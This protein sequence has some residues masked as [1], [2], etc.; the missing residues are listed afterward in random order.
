MPIFEYMCQVCGAGFEQLIMGREASVS[1]PTCGS[2][3]VA[4]QFSTLSAQ[5][6]GGFVGSMG[7]GCGCAPSG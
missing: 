6:T 1:C 3:E 7:S 2:P 5:T 4:K